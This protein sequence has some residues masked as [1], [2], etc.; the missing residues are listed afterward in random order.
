MLP[1]TPKTVSVIMTVRNDADGCALTLASLAN[2][3]QAPDE[4]VVVDGGSTDNTV[5]VIRRLASYNPRIRCIETVGGNIAQGR[6]HAAKQAT[7]EILA[8]IDGGCAAEP[9]WLERLVRPFQTDRETEFVAGFYRIKPRSLLEHV[10]GL[11]TM[12]GQLDPIQPETFN[13]SARSMACLKSLWQRVGGWPEWLCFSEDTLF[14][15]KVRRLNV[16]WKVAE[17]AVVYW[18][19]RRTLRAVGR[20]FYNYGTGRGH[21]QIDAPS[22]A[23]NLRNVGLLVV[24]AGL[25]VVTKWSL[26]VSVLLFAYFFVWTFHDKAIRIARRT[27]RWLAYPVC[28]AVMWV[29]LISGVAGYSVGSFQRLCNRE[30]FHRRMEAYLAG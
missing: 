3:T 18:R 5:Q 26:L 29:V 11:A 20:Q 7:G 25:G 24:T 23:Y 14:D 8:C 21:T 10:V 19:P 16:T 27:D 9:E 30:R 13:P 17:D 15:H 4:I 12:R 1:D 6:N 2:Q 28:M 22:F